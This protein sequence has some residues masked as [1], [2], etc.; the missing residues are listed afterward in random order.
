MPTINRSVGSGDGSGVGTSVGAND[1]WRVG[2]S[3]GAGNGANDGCEVGT[4]VGAGDG[5]RVGSSV[6]AD[7]G[8]NDGCEVGAKVGSPVG[9]NVFDGI[10]V[11]SKDGDAVGSLVGNNDGDAVG[12]SVRVERFVAAG[13]PVGGR[14]RRGACPRNPEEQLADVVELAYGGPGQLGGGGVGRGA[15]NQRRLGDARRELQPVRRSRR[16]GVGTSVSVQLFVHGLGVF[17]R[18]GKRSSIRPPF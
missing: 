9:V 16:R 15:E 13:Q 7:N 11:G 6:G 4:S 8:A 12:A 1:G 14:R 18:R 2:C 3:V 10:G 17:L 5:W